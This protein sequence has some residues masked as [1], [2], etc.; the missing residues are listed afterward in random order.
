[1]GKKKPQNRTRVWGG[2]LDGGMSKFWDD[3]AWLESMRKAHMDTECDGSSK[4][5]AAQH[6]EGCYR[7]QLDEKLRE[8]EAWRAANPGLSDYMKAREAHMDTD[9]TETWVEEAQ[10]IVNGSRAADY[11]DPAQPEN[12]AVRI[13]KAWSAYLGHEV[14]TEDFCWLMVLMKAIRDSHKPKRDNKVDAH[15]YLLVME[16]NE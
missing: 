14:T 8:H 1:M 11:G 10:R 7:Q 12:T 3:H 13:A 5:G 4:C 2:Y 15:G 6:I 9:A 16:Q